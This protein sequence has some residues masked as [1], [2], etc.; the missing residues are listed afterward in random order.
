MAI[1]ITHVTVIDGT[2]AAPKPD[3]TVL[4]EGGRIRSIGNGRVPKDARV[5]DGTGR[6]LIPGLWD[7]HVH[8]LAKPEKAFPKLLASGIT[9]I[10]NM[11]LEAENALGAAVRLRREVEYGAV[12]GPRIVTNGSMIDGPVPVWSGSVT[13]GDAASARRAVR[14][15]KEGGADFVKVYDFLPRDAYFAL[16]AEARRLRLPVVG[17]VPVWVTAEEAARA[18]QK[19]I[20]HLSGIFE[21]CTGDGSVDRDMKQAANLWPISRRESAGR[22]HALLL[23][24]AETY[25]PRTCAPLY[26]LFAE[27]KTWQCPTLVALGEAREA[28][29]RVVREMHAAGVPLLAGTD[30]GGSAKVEPGESLHGELELLVEAG[31]TPMGALQAATRNAAEFLGRNDIGTVEKGKLADVVLLEGNPLEDIRNTRRVAAVILR[32]RIIDTAS[33]EQSSATPGAGRQQGPRR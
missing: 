13:A 17:H 9:G 1:V 4:I 33:S 15:M 20:E 24:A 8:L 3:R 21:S 12:E 26:R 23:H 32:G 14:A 11:H 25:D 27:K 18:G 19:S 29:L 22:M 10:R 6:Y 31:L 28:G 5:I 16:A 30:A 2:G 7:M